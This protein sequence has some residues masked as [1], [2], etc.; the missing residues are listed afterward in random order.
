VAVLSKK[1]QIS[2]EFI[3]LV[4]ICLIYIAG[5][6]WPIMGQGADAAGDVKAVADAK[7]SS[8]KLAKA[9]NQASLSSGDMKKTF[10]LYLGPDSVIACDFPNNEI[11]YTVTVSYINAISNPDTVNCSQVD[12][13]GEPVGWRC[14]SSVELLSG[15]V[16]PSCP[17]MQTGGDTSLFRSVVVEKQAG[18][19]SVEWA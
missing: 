6:I 8:M 7:L 14:S 5:A 13:A 12:V 9:L 2:V 19:I 15:A 18:A 3:L 16:A 10:N 1:G 17:A 4:V 11:D